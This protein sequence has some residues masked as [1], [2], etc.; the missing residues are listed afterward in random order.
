MTIHTTCHYSDVTFYKHLPKGQCYCSSCINY[1]VSPSYCYIKLP[2]YD[3][4]S[5]ITTPTYK[6]K[7]TDR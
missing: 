3:N 5:T 4:Y 7:V 2:N 1:K 6:I